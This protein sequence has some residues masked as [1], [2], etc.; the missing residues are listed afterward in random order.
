[1][2][3][4][5]IA[6]YLA[7]DLKMADRALLTAWDCLPR[8]HEDM[9]LIGGL[10]V[11]HLT[12]PPAEGQ[13]GPVTFDVDFGISIGTSSGMYDTIRATLSKHGFQWT[14]GRFLRKYADFDLHIDLL[15]DDG[16]GK[17]GTVAVD[18]GLQVSLTPGVNRALVCNRI[19]LI[20]GEN[21]V[22]ARSAQR[23]RVAEI[24]PLLV[25]KLNAFAD[26]KAPKDAHDILY[27]VMNYLDGAEKALDA[28]SAEKSLG[29]PGMQVALE[30]LRKDFSS[31]DSNGPIS[32]AAFRLND[33]H[34][35]APFREESGLIRTQFVT[36]ALELLRD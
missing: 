15:T 22:G 21:L 34:N 35:T 27:L 36:L 18:D 33:L 11:G 32:C 13:P 6:G 20:E 24:G 4:A 9:V 5:S 16:S 26:R 17:R 2:K 31:P 10:A 25:L 23:V 7:G 12:N 19:R 14:G 1:M 8:F 30:C 29:N 3:H 28:F